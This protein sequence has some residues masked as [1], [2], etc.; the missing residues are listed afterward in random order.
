MKPPTIPE[1]VPNPDNPDDRTVRLTLTSARIGDSKLSKDGE[2]LYYPAAYDKGYNLWV[3][4]T[5]TR[6]TGS[7]LKLTPAAAA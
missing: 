7:C 2:K 1:F 3:L 4:S 5:R 6:E